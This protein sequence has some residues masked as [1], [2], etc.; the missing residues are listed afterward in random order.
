M[1]SRASC[2]FIEHSAAAGSHNRSVFRNSTIVAWILLAQ[3]MLSCKHRCELLGGLSFLPY[4]GR[5][6]PPINDQRLPAN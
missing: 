6:R 1:S 3:L 5:C 4:S 2:N